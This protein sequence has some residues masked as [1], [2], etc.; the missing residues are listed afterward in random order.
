MLAQ[1]LNGLHPYVPGEQP[2]DRTYIKLNANENPYPPHESVGRAVQ[3]AAAEK[4]SLLGLYPDPDVDSLRAEI[5]AMLNATGGC[6]GNTHVDGSTCSP[7][8]RNRLPFTITPD[9][10]YCGN[11]SDE[12]LSFV[13]YTFFDADRPL[14]QPEFSYSFY[15]VYC[16]FYRI[17]MLPVPLRPDWSLDTEAMLRA[18]QEHNSSI[19]L[20]NPNAPTGI[21]LSRK[22]V[23][24][25]LLQAP[26]DRVFVVDEA[27][28]DFAE[29]SCLPLLAEFKNLVIVRTFSKS[30]S[31]AGMRLGYIVAAPELVRAVFTVKNSVNHF[32]V[33]FVAKT[34]AEASC[35]AAWYYAKNAQEIIRERGDFTAFLR[36]KGWFV[37]DSSTNFVFARK[38]GRTGDDIYQAA[39]QAGILIRLFRTPGIENFVRITIG[40][41]EQML[42]LKKVLEVL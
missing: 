40:T 23:R 42:A 35:R 7:D 8:E 3:Q 1:R 2:T 14:V 37:I 36:G 32:P 22:A 6:F 30:L 15:P 39:K 41:H 5:A 20:A 24:D 31:F 28:C 38:D 10:I 18:A 33:D 16:G 4:L 17:P 21:A 29:E 11:G 13:F 9:M 12:V 19:I 26:K 34:A 25:M 27:Y